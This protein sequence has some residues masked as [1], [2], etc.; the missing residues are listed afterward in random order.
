MR[1]SVVVITI[2]GSFLFLSSCTK[3]WVCECTISSG[4]T[5][6]VTEEKIEASS[7]S[8]ASDECESKDESTFGSCELKP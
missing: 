6:L 5:S 8:K 2:I 3:D 7:F 1:K 4:G